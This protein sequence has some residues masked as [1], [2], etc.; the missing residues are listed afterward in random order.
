MRKLTLLSVAF[1]LVAMSF[2]GCDDT[3]PSEPSYAGIAQFGVQGSSADKTNIQ[4]DFR[5]AKG[6][7]GEVFI[8]F[9]IGGHPNDASVWCDGRGIYE[10]AGETSFEIVYWALRRDGLP[11]P[12]CTPD[13]W[14]GGLPTRI[15]CS[16]REDGKGPA[17]ATL[18][19]RYTSHTCDS[20]PN[21]CRALQ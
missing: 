20:K 15:T 18:V 1:A 3:I 2:V 8:E 12:P 10:N 13:W 6:V 7:S 16:M 4:I 9:G 21:F 19:M 11:L 17:Y 5:C 14:G